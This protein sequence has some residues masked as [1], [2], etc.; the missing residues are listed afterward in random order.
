MGVIEYEQCRL[1]ADGMTEQVHQEVSRQNCPSSRRDASTSF[2]LFEAETE[3]R[4]QQ[5]R[6]RRESG[7]R[8]QQR[9]KTS[10]AA[11]EVFAEPQQRVE[12]SAPD[13]VRRRPLECVTLYTHHSDAMR[14][15]TFHRGRQKTTLPNTGV[16]FND[17]NT[18]RPGVEQRFKA[19][20]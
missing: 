13:V 2:V 18:S 9:H 10:L 17:N 6:E 8:L 7:R 14:E 4:I 11:D 15:R 16:P 1:V 12:Q 19:L 20:F 5:R 3:D